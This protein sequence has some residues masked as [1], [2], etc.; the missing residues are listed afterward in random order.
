M[1]VTGTEIETIVERG[2][3]KEDPMIRGT[4]TVTGWTGTHTVETILIRTVAT[5]TETP[6]IVRM[7]TVVADMGTSIGSVG[8]P[9]G[10]VTGVE[11]RGNIRMENE[12]PRTGI[13]IIIV[14][15][16]EQIVTSIMC[17]HDGLISRV[18][19][20]ATGVVL[21]VEVVGAQGIAVGTEE[22]V[23]ETGDT[24]NVS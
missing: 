9:V 15:S 13:E 17:L 23:E 18:M 10:I 24:N 6:M 2:G 21:R 11:G 12:V 3:E 14:A 5:E 1:I 19:K 22:D 4:V 8:R 7:F 16:G 20:G